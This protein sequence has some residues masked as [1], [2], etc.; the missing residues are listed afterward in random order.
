M[1]VVR[2]LFSPL[3]SALLLALTAALLGASS[4][5]RRDRRSRW[6]PHPA[7]SA[8]FS[9]SPVPPTPS[10]D[11]MPAPAAPA[12]TFWEW[13]RICYSKD[14]APEIR[15]V[16][17]SRGGSSLTPG[18][19]CRWKS[20]RLSRSRSIHSRFRAKKRRLI[21]FRAS[22]HFSGS[23]DGDA[24]LVARRT[25]QSSMPNRSFCAHG[26][27][28]ETIFDARSDDGIDDVLCLDFG[29]GARS[30]TR[31]CSGPLSC[32]KPARCPKNAKRF[33]R[34]LTTLLCSM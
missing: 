12:T 31:F 21:C 1:K 14:C 2:K 9:A 8:R 16:H 24:E 34:K 17:F 29:S 22:W 15:S 11:T 20:R 7:L 5:L 18:R 26:F 10:P 25:L 32:R 6:R 23:T 28:R 30:G 4:D 13:M 33:C 19:I 27:V 3:L